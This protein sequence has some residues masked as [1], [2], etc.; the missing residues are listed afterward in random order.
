MNLVS[1][2]TNSAGL[3]YRTLQQVRDDRLSVTEVAAQG[4]LRPSATRFIEPHHDIARAIQREL[5]RF[6]DNGRVI[7]TDQ[8]LNG[9]HGAVDDSRIEVAAISSSTASP[10]VAPGRTE[11][12]SR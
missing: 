10:I 4:G 5:H 11:N 2:E 7:Q 9:V 1:V 12:C 3:V 8:R 6:H